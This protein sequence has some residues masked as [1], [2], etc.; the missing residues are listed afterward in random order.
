M[1]RPYRVPGISPDSAD[2]LVD[3]DYRI[4]ARARSYGPHRAAISEHRETDDAY[5]R[6]DDRSTQDRTGARRNERPGSGR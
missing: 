6:L 3:L 2:V 1:V 4:V 5:E